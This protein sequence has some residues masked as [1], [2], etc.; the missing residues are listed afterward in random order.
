MLQIYNFFANNGNFRR[1][2]YLCPSFLYLDCF[3]PRSDAKRQ[4]I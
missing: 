1:I 4:K 3:V 2:P